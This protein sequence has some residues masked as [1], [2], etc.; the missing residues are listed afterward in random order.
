MNNNLKKIAPTLKKMNLYDSEEFPLTRY[1]SVNAA[2]QRV[3][4][5]NESKKFT[6]KKNAETKSLK[7][8]RIH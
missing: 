3:Q 6:Q 5:E 7:V 4:T 8:T 2:I 1:T